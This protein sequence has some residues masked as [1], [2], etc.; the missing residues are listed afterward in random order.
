MPK[1]AEPVEQILAEM[2]VQNLR[3]KLAFIRAQIPKI[4]KKGTAP[5]KMGG[6]T[7][8]KAEDVCGDIGDLMAI[9]KIS[10]VPTKVVI[11]S[12]QI[13]DNRASHV[14]AIVSYR[15]IDGDSAEFIDVEAA[16]EGKDFGDKAVPKALTGAKK[17][18]LTQALTMRV[19]DDSEAD[20]LSKGG[21]THQSA[22]PN[23][24]A[25]APARVATTPVYHVEGAK[26]SPISQKQRT[27]MFA[28]AKGNVEL[29]KEVQKKW[30][31]ASSNDISWK[32]YDPICK[33]IERQ[34]S[35]PEPITNE[36]D[37]GF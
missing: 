29:I 15:F 17:Y 34:A 36:E 32:D 20:D 3:E 1:A 31:Y 9:M 28:I 24:S 6:Y 27:R 30:G 25:P 10:M 18:A 11:A 4:E 5:E 23:A 7:F 37:I 2:P 12:H 14:I 35:N 16:G 22:P 21:Q 13:V 33:E 19:G 26:G 8:M